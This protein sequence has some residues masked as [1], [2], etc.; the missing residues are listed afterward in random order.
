[1]SDIS[2]GPGW[3]IASDG[4]WYAPE[5]HPDYVPPPPPPPPAIIR[6]PLADTLPTPD[7]STAQPQPVDPPI[8]AEENQDIGPVVLLARTQST[9]VVGRAYELEYPAHAQCAYQVYEGIEGDFDRF[10]CASCRMTVYRKR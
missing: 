10:Q 9:F 2:Q 5:Q 4:K 7:S 1:M 8:E 3:W 6:Q